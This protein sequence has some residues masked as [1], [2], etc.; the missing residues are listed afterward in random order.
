[1][2]QATLRQ[3][4]ALTVFHLLARACL[5]R[6]EQGTR[7]AEA[8]N[9]RVLSGIL[10]RHRHTE[11]GRRFGF[12]G[13]A[14]SAP[15]IDAY[16]ATVPLS[17]YADYEAAIERIAA[18]EQN[19]L[20]ADRVTM[21][22]RSAGTTGRSKRIPRTR[23]AQGHALRLT[24]LAARAV[25]DRDIPAMRQRRRGINLLS[26]VGAPS[27]AAGQVPEMSGPNAGLRR[28][29]QQIPRLFTSPIPVFEIAHPATAHYLH[30]LFGLRA[31]D[32]LF[33]E[34]TF[35]S[36]LMGLFRVI[37]EH[38]AKL[39]DDLAHGTL[40]AHLTLSAT[41]HVQIAP[42]LAPDPARAAEV[43]A[44]F[45]D[46]LAGIVPRL[47]PSMACIRTVTSGSFAVSLPR[48]RWLAGPTL[49]I[50]SGTYTASEG[51]IGLNRRA[52]GGTDYVLAVG[53]AFFEFI[54]AE[55]ADGSDPPTVTLGQ[56]QVGHDY[57]V[58][59]TTEAGLYRYRLGDVIR[60]TGFHHQAPMFSYQYRRGM[61][62][63]LANEKTSE[64]HAMQALGTTVPD[65]LGVPHALREWVVTGDLDGGMGRYTFYLELDPLIPVPTDLD[66]VATRL[67]R[68]LAAVNEYYD[69]NGREPGQLALPRVA[70]V[71]SGT[72]QA[73]TAL[74]LTRSGHVTP[75]QVKI[76][77]V[78]QDP[79]QLALLQGAVVASSATDCVCD[80][81]TSP[82]G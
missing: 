77:R 66:R 49:P 3:R 74:L 20:T 50:H 6:F 56:L 70:I 8:V 53:T 26:L 30:A 38:Q 76:P 13:L 47:W 79:A 11:F 54:P 10:H 80:T 44:I 81:A 14:S 29:R 75:T 16:K 45:A 15:L 68:A 5:A 1:M 61:L 27:P 17:T 71:A 65:W 64:W 2:P 9:A 19:V 57:E 21:L 60:I 42:H 46:G 36:H 23:R 34:T 43:A 12:G 73:L 18:G 32:A 25:I 67:D 63:N 4:F 35:A 48:L 41:E 40:S 7:Q 72:F 37:E 52:D 39:V 59:L 28:L 51:I 69:R 58:V 82:P 55:L 24:V 31:R 22:G 78:V 62:L 33:I